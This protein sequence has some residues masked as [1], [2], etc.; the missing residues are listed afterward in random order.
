M[1]LEHGL[2]QPIKTGEFLLDEE[3]A[4]EKMQQFRLVNPHYYVLELVKAAHLL[5]TTRI[6][7]EVDSHALEMR[8]N[9]QLIEPAD[10]E[11]L[12]SFAYSERRTNKQRALRHLAIAVQAAGGF[13]LESFQLHVEKPHWRR[14][15]LTPADSMRPMMRL[16]LKRRFRRWHPADV[17][18]KLRSDIP[19]DQILRRRCAYASI[20]IFVHGER[21][22]RGMD[23]KGKALVTVDIESKYERGRLWITDIQD[24]WH[25]FELG[26]MHHGVLISSDTFKSP[27]I[28]GTAIIE[29]RRLTMN[30][31]QSAFVEDAAFAEVRDVVL[32]MAMLRGI[33]MFLETSPVGPRNVEVIRRLVARGQVAFSRFGGR[34]AAV[35]ELYGRFLIAV[36]R[37]FEGFADNLYEANQRLR[38]EEQGSADTH[39]PQETPEPVMPA[40]EDLAIHVSGDIPLHRDAHTPRDFLCNLRSQ[41][42]QTGWMVPE[43]DFELV[44]DNEGWLL[45]WVYLKCYLNRSHPVLRHALENEA[46]PV[47]M[48][49]VTTALVMSNTDMDAASNVACRQQLQELARAM[50]R[51]A[52]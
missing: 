14:D 19:E 26:L 6:E 39:R 47:A 40:R 25:R 18:E 30:L 17:L 43:V 41:L 42:H 51:F 9:G 28:G 20:P 37:H 50:A 10:L 13:R 35:E 16:D 29:S 48:A 46:D 11:N 8:F 27:L 32:R 33:I 34:S 31:S 15:D 44:D 21:I 24:H 1:K 12:A 38:I 7:F 4:R 2:G 3:R 22:S 23:L 49:F 5:G 36:E 52:S 45:R